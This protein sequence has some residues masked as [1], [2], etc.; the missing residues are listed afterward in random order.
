MNIGPS[1]HN[2]LQ[3]FFDYLL[4]SIDTCES[5]FKVKLMYYMRVFQFNGATHT[6]EHKHKGE[7]RSTLNGRC[8]NC[9]AVTFSCSTKRPQT[10][11]LLESVLSS[12]Q[13]KN[14]VFFH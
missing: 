12:I 4:Q 14:E 7:S 1:A 10:Q 6:Q 2:L 9:F 5:Q 11:L 13:L 3:Y 8:I